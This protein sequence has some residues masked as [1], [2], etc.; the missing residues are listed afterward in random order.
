MT[1]TFDLVPVFHILLAG[2]LFCR[3]GYVCKYDHN[4][5][6]PAVV[7]SRDLV[8]LNLGQPTK[9]VVADNKRTDVFELEQGNQQSIG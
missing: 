7:K 4:I 8:I 5:S 2:R 3:D 9:T 1:T 6:A